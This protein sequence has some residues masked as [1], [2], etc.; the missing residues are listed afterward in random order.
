ML[1]AQAIKCGDAEI[2]IAGGQENMSASPHV[3]KG[4]RDGLRMGDWKLVD[5][6][7]VDGLWDVYNQYHMGTTAENVAKKYGSLPRGA[8]CFRRRLAAEGRGRAEGGQVQGRD[9]AGRDPFEEGRPPCS[10]PTSS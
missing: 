2:V 3:L 5:S 7:I 6:M 10:L 9:H 4:S 1:A 8:G